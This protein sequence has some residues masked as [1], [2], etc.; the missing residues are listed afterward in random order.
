MKESR[1]N[2]DEIDT[3]SYHMM[4][5]MSGRAK[6]QAVVDRTSEINLNIE[7]SVAS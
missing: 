6:V 1:K 4:Q 7:F 5:Q 2:V 3:C